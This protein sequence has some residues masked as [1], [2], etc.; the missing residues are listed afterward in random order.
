MRL[1]LA[2]T[3]ALHL[4]MFEE[5]AGRSDNRKSGIAKLFNQTLKQVQN[6]PTFYPPQ[7]QTSELFDLKNFRKDLRSNLTGSRLMSRPQEEGR[8]GR[9]PCRPQAILE[10]R[11]LHPVTVSQ[12][13]SAHLRHQWPQLEAEHIRS[14]PKA[15]EDRGLSQTVQ[16]RSCGGGQAARPIRGRKKLRERK[17][18]AVLRH[19]RSDGTRIER[20]RR[21]TR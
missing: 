10:S 8:V 21:H 1:M 11:P 2:R 13:K 3:P 20:P 15:A 5:N 6:P 4:N 19:N 18:D 16:T 17:I 9:Q 14:V 12:R 7:T